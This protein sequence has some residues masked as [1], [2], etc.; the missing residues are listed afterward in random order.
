VS[1]VANCTRI[2][3]LN[4]LL[5]DDIIGLKTIG[6]RLLVLNSRKVIQRLLVE[7]GAI[8]S[9]RPPLTLMNKWCVPEVLL[10]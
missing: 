9:D 8:Y 3:L 1:I 2:E 10:L 7:R 5:V 4:D 6:S